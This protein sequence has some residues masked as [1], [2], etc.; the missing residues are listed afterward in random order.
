MGVVCSGLNVRDES[1][2]S[3][4]VYISFKTTSL[5]SPSGFLNKS[6]DSKIGVIISLKP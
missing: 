3:S 5:F 2:L 1:F 6:V 4:K